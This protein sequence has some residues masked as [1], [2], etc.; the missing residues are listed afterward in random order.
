MSSKVILTERGRIQTLQIDTT[1]KHN[2]IKYNLY[3]YLY[4]YLYTS[5][6]ESGLRRYGYWC[7][8]GGR[9]ITCLSVSLVG[10]SKILNMSTNVCLLSKEER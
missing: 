5:V 10:P 7:L 2:G 9:Q 4:L 3:L 6:A 8:S 1:K